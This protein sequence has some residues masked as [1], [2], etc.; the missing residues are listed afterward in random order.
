LH[1]HHR[2]D[3][4]ACIAADNASAPNL[5]DNIKQGCRMARLRKQEI[6]RRRKRREERVKARRKVAK[7]KGR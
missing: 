2:L 5:L 1:G 3:S 7:L 4:A 6:K